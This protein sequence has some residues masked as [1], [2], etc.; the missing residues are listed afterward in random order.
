MKSGFCES[1]EHDACGVVMRRPS[2]KTYRCTC[3]CHPSP[4]QKAKPKPRDVDD[5]D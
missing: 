3:D 2:G 1:G 5:E 4:N